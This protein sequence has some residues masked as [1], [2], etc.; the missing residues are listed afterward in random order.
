MI[1]LCRMCTSWVC[2]FVR[3]LMMYMSINAVKAGPWRL[4]LF[5]MHREGRARS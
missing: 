2:V 1:F 3:M 4:C 5:F